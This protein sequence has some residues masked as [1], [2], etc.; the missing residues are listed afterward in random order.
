M[1]L[2]MLLRHR[3]YTVFLVGFSWT[4]LTSKTYDV[5]QYIQTN[6]VEWNIFTAIELE[7]KDKI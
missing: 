5:F 1:F 7:P 4:I 2:L 6:A 3:L